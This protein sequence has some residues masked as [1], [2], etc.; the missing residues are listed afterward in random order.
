MCSKRLFFLFAVV[1]LTGCVA[2]G[3]SQQAEVKPV[4]VTITGT[5]AGGGRGVFGGDD[6]EGK[7]FT[8]S[9]S[10]DPSSAQVGGSSRCPGTSAIARGAAPGSRATAILTIGNASYTFGSKVNSK[11]QASRY[12]KSP[13]GDDGLFTLH[14]DESIGDS[15]SGIDIR[16]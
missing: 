14:I 15:M 11:W 5:A 9:F 12:L 16:V 2:A 8:L 4:V 3:G 6:L 13:C 10:F 1:G 7:P